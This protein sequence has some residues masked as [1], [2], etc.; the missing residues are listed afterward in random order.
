MRTSTEKGRLF[1]V[2]LCGAVL[3]YLVL[4]PYTMVVYGL[5]GHQGAAPDRVDLRV[6]LGEVLAAFRLDMMPMGLHFALIGALIGL[7]LGVWLEARSRRS[8]MENRFLAVETLRQLMVT[9]AHYLLNAVQ[10]IVMYTS[11]ALRKEQ[12]ED[13]KRPLEGI[14]Q[15]AI[16]IEAVVKALQSL[17]SVTTERYTKSGET[18]MI[19]I[20]KEI[21]EK[22][23]ALN[24]NTIESPRYRRIRCLPTQSVP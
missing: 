10:G 15:E 13:K 9:L 12:D 4:H 8:E 18:L 14:K 17:E 5:Y 21:Q 22:M 7:L 20:R 23:E 16:R 24:R 1:L 19:D 3:G 2:A 6:V 11:L